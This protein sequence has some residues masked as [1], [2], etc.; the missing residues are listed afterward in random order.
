MLEP[1]SLEGQT[2]S[3]YYFTFAER[4]SI[5]ALDPA[6]K[7]GIEIL[8]YTETERATMQL[9]AFRTGSSN[10]SGDDLTG[11]YD[12]AFDLRAT[13]LPW[14]D[15]GGRPSLDTSAGPSRTGHHSMASV[16]INQ[17]PQ[18]TLLTDSDHPRLSVHPAD[19]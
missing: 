17:K 4:S 9:G 7:W 19:H 10:S 2:S 8:S 14:Y 13:C 12:L 11:Q 1:F 3:N 18:N 16:I 15:D 6:R 5:D